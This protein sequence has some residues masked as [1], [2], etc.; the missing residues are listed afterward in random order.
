MCLR[1]RALLVF[2]M[3]YSGRLLPDICVNQ[4]SDTE[5]NKRDTQNLAHIEDHIV[6]ESY[7]RL[8]DEFNDEP[9]AEAYDEEDSDECSP[10]N[11]VQPELVKTDK[12]KAKNKV[13]Q[14]LV[15]LCRMLGFRLA[16]EIKDKAPRK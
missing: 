6:F 10:V 1:L 11:L 9:H 7:L 5:K 12:S 14:C 16:P 8:L 15:Q 2:S 3:D 13:S 4:E